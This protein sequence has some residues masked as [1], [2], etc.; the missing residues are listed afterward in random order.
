MQ[1]FDLVRFVSHLTNHKKK[2]TITISNSQLITHHHLPSEA[3]SLDF[4]RV[5][6]RVIIELRLKVILKVSFNDLERENLFGCVYCTFGICSLFCRMNTYS[7]STNMVTAFLNKISGSLD[8]II[9]IYF[10]LSLFH[11]KYLPLR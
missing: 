5:K 4:E 3:H 9:V 7:S 11:I 8:D 6:L 2:H 1:L 10:A